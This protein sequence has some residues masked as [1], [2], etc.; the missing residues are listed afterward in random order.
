MQYGILYLN[1][2][3]DANMNCTYTTI[4]HNKTGLI[5]NNKSVTI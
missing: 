5:N 4:T 2:E 1:I 3:L